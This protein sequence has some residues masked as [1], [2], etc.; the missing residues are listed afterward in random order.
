MTKLKKMNIYQAVSDSLNKKGILPFSAREWNSGNV[1]QIIRWN[2]RNS[3]EYVKFPEVVREYNLV[4]KQLENEKSRQ[5][6]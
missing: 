3:G 6:K 1:Q 4:L 2:T 5:V